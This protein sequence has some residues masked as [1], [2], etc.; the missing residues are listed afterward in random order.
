MVTIQFL[1]VTVLALATYVANAQTNPVAVQAAPTNAESQTTKTQPTVSLVAAVPQR[2]QNRAEFACRATRETAEQY[3][4][5]LNERSM[6]LGNL[7][8]ELV[9]M[10][11]LGLAGVIQGSDC[12]VVGFKK[13]EAR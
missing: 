13:P 7:G 4:R 2:W 12:L 11:S 1:V 8:W 9:S 3:Q 5:R 10:T 6:Q